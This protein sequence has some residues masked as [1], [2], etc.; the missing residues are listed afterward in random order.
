MAT[1]L[2]Q[3]F[4]DKCYRLQES[5]ERWFVQNSSLVGGMERTAWALIFLLPDRFGEN[6]LKTTSLNTTLECLTCY[7]DFVWMKFAHLLKREKISVDQ[8]VR[9]QLEKVPFF[10]E[11]NMRIAS[12]LTIIEHTELLCEILATRI[13]PLVP[14]FTWM[15]ITLIELT[16]C[17]LRLKLLKAERGAILAHRT[18]PSRSVEEEQDGD[19]DFVDV[20]QQYY[21][22]GRKVRQNLMSVQ[23]GVNKKKE[24]MRTRD[25]KQ[26]TEVDLYI[27]FGELLWI[28]R[29]L[30]YLYLLYKNGRQSWWPWIISGLIDFASI[31]CSQ[32]K[33]LNK[34][35]SKEMVHRKLQLLFY[36]LRSPFFE[37]VFGGER[38]TATTT[39]LADVSRKI[40]GISAL[41]AIAIE[42]LKVYRTRYFYTAGSK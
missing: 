5:Y 31:R 10:P 2:Q 29:P 8:P 35:E 6:E 19:D 13:T 20:D 18:I 37:T 3:N 28:L 7:H 15:V 21:S 22:D 38:A 11:S 24:N 33:K 41:L 12:T 25:V 14:N 30:I 16:K 36:L 4:T 1:S 9:S 40:P 42:F 23:R 39:K 26:P 17:F 32:N 27:I 34:A